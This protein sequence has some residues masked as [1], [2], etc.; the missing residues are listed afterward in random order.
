[1][2]AIGKIRQLLQVDDDEFLA[3]LLVLQQA[4]KSTLRD[5]PRQRHLTAFVGRRCI[6]TGARALTLMPAARGLAEA[7]SDSAPDPH[8]LL[9][10]SLGGFQV[11]EV[12]LS[13]YS[14]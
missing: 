13:R 7:R 8:M 12:H 14:L 2:G 3:T 4:A 1:R 5:A 11:T 9:G 10:R 6:A